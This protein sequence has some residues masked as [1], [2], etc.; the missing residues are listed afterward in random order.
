M[1]S[2]ISVVLMF[3]REVDRAT[4]LIAP[5]TL[6]QVLRRELLA[7]LSMALTRRHPIHLIHI[8]RQAIMVRHRRI[9]RLILQPERCQEQGRLQLLPGSA[10]RGIIG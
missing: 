8:A 5:T 6:L 7:T 4:L 3:L 10:R 1:V 9:T 2:Q